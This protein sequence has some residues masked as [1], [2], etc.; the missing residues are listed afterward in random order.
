VTYA[1]VAANVLVYAPGDLLWHQAR[2]WVY[3]CL[4]HDRLAVSHGEVWRLVSGTFVHANFLHISLNML[5]LIAFGRVLERLQGHW[6]FLVTYLVS[7]L[8]GSLL[9]QALSSAPL[10]MGASGAVYGLCGA[11]LCWILLRKPLSRRARVL[12]FVGWTVLLVVLDQV[13]AVVIE[14]GMDMGI[15]ISAH[16]GG[17]VGGACLGY[18]FFAVP[19]APEES[20]KPPMRLAA[21]GGLAVLLLGLSWI[22][23]AWPPEDPRQAALTE[24]STIQDMLE[25]GDLERAVDVWRR[26]DGSSE[27]HRLVGYGLYDRLMAE[28]R[29]NL[30]GDV[31]AQLHESARES[32]RREAKARRVSPEI[33]NEVAWYGAL[34]GVDL[35]EARDSA[36]LAVRMVRAQ[37]PHKLWGWLTSRS[38]LRE[39]EG[40]CLNTLGW[41]KLLLGEK[42]SALRD[43][44]EAAE[45]CPLG[46]NFLY[47]ALAYF[48]VGNAPEARRAAVEAAAAGGLSRYEQVLLESLEED[49]KGT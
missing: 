26:A 32:L 40:T 33:L 25:A 19:W 41:V 38:E 13:F 9:F 4:G 37:F 24:E 28:N 29:R 43:L 18:F 44:K 45:I 31:L 22:A 35:D 34:R 27:H 10:G 14:Q 2:F 47:L 48:Q 30:A 11:T 6:R 21:A 15:A 7:G 3:A 20:P 42:E 49:L 1:L 46:S 23:F 12:K 16:F 5:A 36:E 8:A 39:K 17:F